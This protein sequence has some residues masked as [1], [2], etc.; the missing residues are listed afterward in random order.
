MILVTGAS[1]T[2]GTPVTRLLAEA[3]ADVHG[4]SRRAREPAAGVTWH[5]GDLWKGEGIDAALEGVETIVHC[6]SDPFHTKRDLAA[7]RR[8]VEAAR[9]QGAPHLIYI[10]IV[11]V[12]TIPYSYY[13]TKH[14]VERLIEDSGLP[15]TILRTTQFH[16]LPDMVFAVLTKI[17][18]VVALPRNLR[19]QPIDVGEV[20]E[21]LTELALAAGPARRVEDMGGPEVLTAEEMMRDYLAAR[22]LRKPV[23]LPLPLPGK[24]ARG[25]REGRHLTPDRAVGKRT[26]R[27]FLDETRTHR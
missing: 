9:G 8:L 12:D 13:R 4:L 6:A 15:Y 3:G 2:L 25:F 18:G 5:K 20:A 24:A 19:D 10:S 1:G 11:G 23:R 17:P 7:T 26:W 21:R 27:Q 16:T 22:G 14:A